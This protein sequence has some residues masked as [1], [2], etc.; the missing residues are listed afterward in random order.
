MEK[1]ERNFWIK[2]LSIS[3]LP[4]ILAPLAL[5]IMM[6]FHIGIFKDPFGNN[7]EKT[8]L[9]DNY[10]VTG[11][12]YS[13]SFNPTDTSF[14]VWFQDIKD[15]TSAGMGKVVIPSDNNDYRLTSRKVFD[16]LIVMT[17]DSIGFSFKNFKSK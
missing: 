10:E 5:F 16:S 13:S 8:V 3:C 2:E 4:Y 6:R 11:K 9:S 7:T 14:E 1:Q 12:S 15:S 17:K